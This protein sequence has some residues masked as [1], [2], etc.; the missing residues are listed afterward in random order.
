MDGFKEWN[1]ESSFLNRFHSPSPSLSLSSS[2]LSTMASTPRNGDYIES[3][4]ERLRRT[5]LQTAVEVALDHA[6]E[7]QPGKIS[8]TVEFRPYRGYFHVCLRPKR[9]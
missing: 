9:G 4:S 2:S 1:K 7:T 8:K 6:S 3:S 5:T